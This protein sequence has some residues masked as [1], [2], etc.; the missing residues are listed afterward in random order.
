M[1][2][3]DLGGKFALLWSALGSHFVRAET[4][5]SCAGYIRDDGFSASGRRLRNGCTGV[6][7]VV[8]CDRF[9]PGARCE[10]G[11]D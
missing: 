6:R 2:R 9:E 10:I 7:N 4:S 5:A 8:M 11:Q 1:G 3:F